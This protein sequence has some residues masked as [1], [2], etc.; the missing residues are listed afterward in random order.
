MEYLSQERHDQI[1]AELDNLINVEY[2]VR[3]M[4]GFHGQ[5]SVLTYCS[6]RRWSVPHERV[7]SLNEHYL[8]VIQ[9]WQEIFVSCQNCITF[10]I[11]NRIE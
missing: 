11:S 5:D 9:F 7:E 2:L 3:K 10:V 4:A 1:A 8:K 6:R